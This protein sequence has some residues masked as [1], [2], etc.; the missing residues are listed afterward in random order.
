MKVGATSTPFHIRLRELRDAHRLSLRALA[1][2]L[3]DEGVSITHTA[4]RKWELGDEQNRPPKPEYIAALC[5]VF[6]ILPSFLLEDIFD[7]KKSNKDRIS[8][9]SDVDLLTEEEHESLLNLK[10]LFLNGNN[11]QKTGQLINEKGKH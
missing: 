5:R 3:Q 2:S 7:T 1:A 6:N 8:K 10:R 11:N 4:I 9:W